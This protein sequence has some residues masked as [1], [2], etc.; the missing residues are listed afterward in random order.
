M[1]LTNA[2]H[3]S[4]KNSPV[5]QLLSRLIR[6]E[7]ERGGDTNCGPGGSVIQQ[8]WAAFMAGHGVNVSPAN[9]ETVFDSFRGIR[10]E[11]NANS[12]V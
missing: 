3:D 7:V 10:D 8:L 11:I 4:V 6:E 12:E 1:R 5:G 2:M 9:G